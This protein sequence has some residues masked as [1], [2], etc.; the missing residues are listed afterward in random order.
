MTTQ[1]KSSLVLK[2][3]YAA[4][5][6]DPIHVGSG[7]TRLGRVDL[8]IVRDPATNLPKIP[9]SSI[10]GVSRAATALR[11]NNTT[12]A[13]KSD[14][15]IGGRNQCGDK[16]CPVCVP[17]GFTSG[18]NSLHGMAQFCDAHVLFFPVYTMAGT[19]WIACSDSLREI[20]GV[21][22]NEPSS[23]NTCRVAAGLEI[24]TFNGSKKINLGWLL[25]DGDDNNPFAVSPELNLVPEAIR[26]RAV[27]VHS[28]IFSRLVNANL[29]I[30]TSVSI[31]PATGAADEGALFSY[32]AL[33]R[34]TVLGFE[35]LYADP[36]HFKVNRKKITMS[37]EEVRGH[38]QEGLEM[39]DV[40]GVGGMNTRGFGRLRV[41][42]LGGRP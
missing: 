27:L 3:L 41:V 21:E 15:K 19:A 18:K 42:D 5:A 7:A 30:R 6:V 25:L 40:L 8:P 23:P 10:A 35:V 17:Y 37:R 9:G 13:G 29:E 16:D 14:E 24:P 11:N 1:S 39:L 28:T 22:I 32:E 2:H 34:G 31:D 4:L 33:P 36:S 38:V 12:C 26:K 20:V